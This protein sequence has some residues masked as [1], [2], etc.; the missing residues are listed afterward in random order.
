MF[1]RDFSTPT[2]VQTGSQSFRT[3]PVD[4]TTYLL[5]A[6]PPGFESFDYYNLR[7]QIN[8]DLRFAGRNLDNGVTVIR[9][10]EPRREDSSRKSKSTPNFSVLENELNSLSLVDEETQGM[11]KKKVS[12]A[13]ELGLS[14]THVKIILETPDQPPKLRPEILSS[15]TRGA[16]AGVTVA[17]PLKLNFKQPA[18]DYISFREKIHTNCVCLENV[19]L[20][21][22]NLLGTIK[23]KN[24]AFEKS[25]TVR[26]THNSWKDTLDIPCTYVPAAG[27]SNTDT[28]SFEIKI[29]PNFN[30][31]EKVEFCI[32]YETASQQFWDNN[33]GNNYGIVPNDWHEEDHKLSG[34]VFSI[35]AFEKNDWGKYSS[36]TSLDTSVPYW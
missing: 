14:L 36:W 24:L 11:G 28:F 3:M 15:L 8:T 26:F 19:I 30:P 18:S 23:V 25:V 1:E 22:Y 29:P 13:D 4:F 35:D 5:S 6:S 7:D 2:S 20:K 12:F 34:N 31:H 32:R 16:N 17:P 27:A 33:N 9:A 21:D 10:G